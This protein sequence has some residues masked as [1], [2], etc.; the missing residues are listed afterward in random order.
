MTPARFTLLL[1]A[2]ALI[3]AAGFGG[4]A[5]RTSQL[6]D[7]I[8]RFESRSDRLKTENEESEDALRTLK[9]QHQ[10]IKQTSSR[11]NM[12]QKQ[13]VAAIKK[14]NSE[15]SKLRADNDDLAV[16]VNALV[17]APTVE[18]M[19]DDDAIRELDERGLEYTLQYRD[20]SCSDYRGHF[21]ERG[22]G[23]D[24]VLD[25]RPDPG[26]RMA[27]GS[28]VHLYLFDRYSNWEIGCSDSD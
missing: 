5:L 6:A 9:Q 25:Q 16:Q 26:T 4:W 8:D 28:T 20:G 3:A 7:D 19:L 10:D 27:T 11:S 18:G 17:E 21:I 13:I 1:I 12:K 15:R 24:T 2:L 23:W 22:F 14:L